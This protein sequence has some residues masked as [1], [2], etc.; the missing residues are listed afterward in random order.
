MAAPS[1]HRTSTACQLRAVSVRVGGVS[2]IEHCDLAIPNGDFL[3]LVG[4]NGAG[5]TT[6]IR[7]CLGLL[8]VDEGEVCLFGSPLRRFRNWSRVSYAPQ[9]FPDCRS[10]PISVAEFI[11]SGQTGPSLLDRGS[12]ARV[13]AAAEELGVWQ[14]RRR[15]VED[16]SGGQQRRVLIARALSRDSDLLFLDEPTAGLDG[17][18]QQQ[19]A[20]S[21][22]RRRD[23][24][25]TTVVVT[26]EH[27][28]VS[29][30]ARRCL[31]VE[32]TG[33]RHC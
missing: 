3:V 24:G 6:L 25:G 21:L 17:P 26:H 27:T 31:V 8:P 33:L 12:A 32:R 9:Q 11:A 5:K 18:G 10:I 7:A 23:A 29:D 30:L 28:A 13:K 2:V 19:L 22:R 15:R 16:L 1:T 4:S 20:E 14:V